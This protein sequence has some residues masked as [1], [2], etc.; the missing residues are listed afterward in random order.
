MIRAARTLAKRVLRRV[1]LLDHL[2]E[3]VRGTRQADQSVRA[4]A[5]PFV[6][7]PNPAHV[8]AARIAAERTTYNACTNVHELPQ[9]FHYWSNKYLRPKV[10]ACGFTHPDLFFALYLEKALKRRDGKKHVVSL[11]AGNCDTEVRVARILIDR[12]Y[13]DFVIECADINEEMLA[14]GKALAEQSGVASQVVPLMLDFNRWKPAREYDA[15]LANQSLHHMLELEA[16]FEATKQ[17]IG[18]AG[19]FITS[20]MIGRNGHQRWPEALAIVNEFWSELPAK[21]RYHHQ[22]GR[23]EE[24]FLDWDCSTEGFEGIRAQDILPLLVDRFHFDFFAGFANVI[25]P[26]IDRGFGHNFNAEGEWDRDFIDRVHARDEREI[27]AGTIKPTHMF[28]VMRNDGPGEQL[29]ADGLSPRHCL[30]VP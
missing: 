19:T 1:G 16:V 6:T 9:I 27:R 5:R 26:F 3:L 17:A 20:D 13:T 30:R 21:Y 15:V 28:A 11:G 22:L 12:G 7:V 24:T 8:Y 14:R 25:D 2:K 18:S 23:H 10:E 4:A 29:Y